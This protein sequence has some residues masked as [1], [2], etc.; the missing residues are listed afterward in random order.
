M[1][2]NLAAAT[3]REPAKIHLDASTAVTTAGQQ[4]ELALTLSYDEG[5]EVI[6]SPRLQ[7]WGEMELLAV[8]VAPQRWVNGQ[9]QYTV[10][11]DTT[12]LMPG[13]Y[14]TPVFNV[15]V[16]EGSEHWQLQTESLPVEVLSSFDNHPVD[17]QDIVGLPRHQETSSS[18]S[19][20]IWT[21]ITLLA[22]AVVLASSPAQIINHQNHQP[23]TFCPGFC[24][25]RC[26]NRSN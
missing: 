26:G 16:F 13:Q 25:Q 5:I 22:V 24:Q 4:I 6:F 23:A 9:W 15:D 7:N 20:L 17:I 19:S 14:Q 10:F 11:M 1:F 3:E 12:F 21:A 8:D 2:S 18:V